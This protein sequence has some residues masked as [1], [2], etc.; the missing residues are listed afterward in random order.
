MPLPMV[1]EVWKK[2]LMQ[3]KLSLRPIPIIIGFVLFILAG[4]SNQDHYNKG[5]AGRMMRAGNLA[6]LKSY[7][8]NNPG[9]IEL[10]NVLD[11][12]PLMEAA[13]DGNEEAVRLLLKMGANVKA[14]GSGQNNA[15][16]WA[17]VNGNVNVA[18]LLIASNVDVN[19]R[20]DKGETP[21]DIAKRN[22]HELFVTYL[23][24]YGGKNSGELSVTPV[25]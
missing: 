11:M 8:E 9:S 2:L 16:H 17:A 24:A 12:T 23:R 6:E 4:L 15:L 1:N 10:K 20:S 14:T 13:F 19:A 25:P 7:I 3:W 5:R 18:N 22:R 21:L